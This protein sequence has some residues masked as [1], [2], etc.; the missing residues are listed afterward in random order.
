MRARACV[1]THLELSNEGRTHE[2]EATPVRNALVVLLPQ[3]SLLLCQ[4][5]CN[6]GSCMLVF[7]CSWFFLVEVFPACC[8]YQTCFVIQIKACAMALQLRGLSSHMKAYAQPPHMTSSDPQ[9]HCCILTSRKHSANQSQRS[10]T[11]HVTKASLLVC[12]LHSS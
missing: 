12:I 3:K 5:L 2:Q 8:A 7:V 10:C 1:H 9:D 11:V 4:Y 6:T